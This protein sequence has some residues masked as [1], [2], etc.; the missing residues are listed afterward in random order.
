[1]SEAP[2]QRMAPSVPQAARE[3]ANDAGEPFNA[4]L[5]LLRHAEA[6]LLLAHPTPGMKVL[7]FGGGNGYQAKRIAEHG[8]D[9]ASIDISGRA[10]PAVQ[11]FPVRDY[12]GVTIPFGDA[13]FDVVFSSSV[14]EHLRDLPTTLREVRR[15]LKPQ[16]F[17]VHIMPSPVWR[18]WT[19]ATHYP[20]FV[21]R[22]FQS[23]RA[24]AGAASALP[25]RRSR[26]RRF[27]SLI[28]GALIE[29][30][31]GEFPSAFAELYHYRRD[32]WCRVF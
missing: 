25:D 29:P 30:P 2:P 23:R 5:E 22:M 27:A 8:C 21:K 20:Y 24:G 13:T 32:V 7:D 14:L 9:V 1:M 17:A 3:G 18:F 4:N 16:G 26:L 6:E 31:H 28:K 12:D 11:Y 19:I 10:R 15:V